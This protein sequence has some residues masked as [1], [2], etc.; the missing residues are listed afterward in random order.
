[1]LVNSL[2]FLC[3]FSV[4][5]VLY[6]L[7]RKQIKIQNWL[8]LIASYYF[9]SVANWKMCVLLMAATIVFYV[10]GLLIQK[11]NDNN[12]KAASIFT[13]IGVIAGVG[14]LLYFKYLN[15][16][17]QSF[18]DLFNLMGLHCNPTTF[19]IIMPV[20]ISFFTFK[21]I[22]YV[23]EIRNEEI[24]ATQ[25]FIDF[26]TFVCF[27]PT[28]MS[29][30]IDRPSSFIPQ[31]QK[32]R[33]YDAQQITHGLQQILWGIF[34]K[35]VIADNLAVVVDDA[36]GNPE[37]TGSTYLLA[38]LLYPIQMYADFSGYSDMAIGV[39]KLLGLKVAIN[40]NYPLFAK[41]IA[42]FWRRWH[43]SL[44]SWVT[45][46][47]YMP[48]NFNFRKWA[49]TGMCLAIIIN[50][51]IVGLWHGAN[52][53]FAAYGL[54]HGLLF[55][56]LIF[57]G[58]MSDKTPI[59]VTKH[60]LP[61]WKDVLKMLLTFILVSIGLVIF[62]E[63]SLSDTFA[64]YC[65]I[66]QRSLVSVP[67]FIGMNNATFLVMIPYILFLAVVDWRGRN[68]E[69]PIFLKNGHNLKSFLLYAFMVASIWFLGAD[70]TSFIYF[71]F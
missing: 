9:Y 2:Q 13:T 41:N 61:Y 46:Y 68:K 40:F 22:S 30:P 60:D 67:R 6:W 53:T 28:I 11:Y 37:L 59:K 21:L 48:L 23:L 43:I 38:M 18:A 50:F 4:V 49:K 33:S 17:V 56:P 20:G 26:A 70:S 58:A 39:A 7:L 62:R 29:G 25:N 5:F 31:L 14:L 66:F 34:K 15:F 32:E 10:I 35:M 12:E 65:Q 57:S 55:I 8:L 47:V 36:F 51:V 1:M 27:F 16:F 54:Y 19:N 52:W 3:F 45:D 69:C 64:F 71:Q 24:E 44:T 63:L 42:D